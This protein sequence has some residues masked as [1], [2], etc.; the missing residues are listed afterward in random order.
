M[1]ICLYIFLSF[2]L[3]V[4]NCK[5][6]KT[7]STHVLLKNQTSKIEN[8][9]KGDYKTKNVSKSVND[10]MFNKRINPPQTPYEEQVTQKSITIKLNHDDDTLKNVESLKPDNLNSKV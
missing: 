5:S 3:T 7:E 9:I 2:S 8:N 6:K 10:A 4:I 1:I